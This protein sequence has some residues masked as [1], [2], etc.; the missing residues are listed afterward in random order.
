LILAQAAIYVA[1]APKSDAC[2]RAIS[3][4]VADVRERRTVPVP[5]HLKPGARARGEGSGAGREY[6]SPHADP[7]RAAAQHYGIEKVYY[8]P[9]ERGAEGKIRQALAE[10]RGIR[11]REEAGGAPAQRQS[12]ETS[13]ERT[14]PTASERPG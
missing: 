3:E 6:V 12:N 10:A 4:A 8:N 5:L 1:C 2:T 11:Q 13:E 9:G 7:E 14:S